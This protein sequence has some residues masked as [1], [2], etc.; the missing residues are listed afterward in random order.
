MTATELVWLCSRA[1][2]LCA[3]LSN[4]SLATMLVHHQQSKNACKSGI[5]PSHC[6]LLVKLHLSLTCW[7]PFDVRTRLLLCK[8]LQPCADV[9]TCGVQSINLMSAHGG[10][11]EGYCLMQVIRGAEACN[12]PTGQDAHNVLRL[13]RA[14]SST[15]RKASVEP[16]PE[17]KPCTLSSC[18]AHPIYSSLSPPPL[19]PQRLPLLPN[20]ACNAKGASCYCLTVARSSASGCTTL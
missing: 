10:T 7:T 19:C 6:C 18:F 13:Y 4:R 12:L 5:S 20:H 14:Q 9:S 16:N 15:N 1:S 2:A 17:G 11:V 8:A 3:P